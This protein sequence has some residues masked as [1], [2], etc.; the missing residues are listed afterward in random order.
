MMVENEKHFEKKKVNLWMIS[1]FVLVVI[2]I[3]VLIVFAKEQSGILSEKKAS[4]KFITF[5][6][7]VGSTSPS[8][9][10]TAIEET[11]GLYKISFVADGMPSEGYLSKDGNIILFGKLLPDEYK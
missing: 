6:G 1:T 3:V 5:I 4:D 7:Y 2:L 11:N 9:T 8:I 10:V